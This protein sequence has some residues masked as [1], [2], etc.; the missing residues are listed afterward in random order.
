MMNDTIDNDVSEEDTVGDESNAERLS[1]VDAIAARREAEILDESGENE[2]DIDEDDDIDE[3]EL[4]NDKKSLDEQLINVKIDG[5]AFDLPLSEVISGYQKNAVASERLRAATER[6]K[7]V[8]RREAE[9]SSK[10]N[11]SESLPDSIDNGEGDNSEAKRIYDQLFFGDDD[12]GVKVIDELLQR[13][14]QDPTINSEQVV[15][16]AKEQVLLTIQYND[17]LERFKQN[18]PDI[19]QDDFLAEKAMSLLNEAAAQSKTY[20]EAFTKVGDDTM[21]W[22]NKYRQGDRQQRKAG[23]EDEPTRRS[24]RADRPP[25]KK[26]ETIADVIAEMRKSRGLSS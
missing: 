6:L 19:V 15:S 26:E 12:D 24:V 7:E 20:D 4:D 16:Q 13:R 11:V 22:V 8:E 3:K 14:G 17:A 2:T 10:S 9:L 5:E 1:A 23:L 21:L 25:P 18:Y